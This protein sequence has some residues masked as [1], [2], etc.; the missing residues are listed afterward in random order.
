MPGATDPAAED[1][2][3]FERRLGEMVASEK[4]SK[5]RGGLLMGAIATCTAVGSCH[6]LEEAR[7]SSSLVFRALASQGA[8]VISMTSLVLLLIFGFKRVSRKDMPILRNLRSILGIFRMQCDD[9]GH[10]ILNPTSD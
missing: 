9:D 1:L 8:F 3:A 5:C 2:R 4:P 10:L 7:E 6:L